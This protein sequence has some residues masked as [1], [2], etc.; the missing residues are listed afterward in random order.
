MNFEPFDTGLIRQHLRGA[1]P[2]LQG[3][4]GA[5][6]YAAVKELRSFRTPTAYVVFAEDENTGKFP[7]SIGVGVQEAM[8]RF[9]VVLALRNYN[10]RAGEQ[11]DAEARRLIGLTRRAL[12]GHKPRASGA[13]VVGWMSGQVL[14]Y[15]ASVLLF[16]DRYELQQLLHKDDCPG[17]C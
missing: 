5:A 1:V 16:A 8:V 10:E 15:D 11:M 13:N 12:I 7:T 9:G 4:G 3:V 17:R 14:D 6:D 2:E